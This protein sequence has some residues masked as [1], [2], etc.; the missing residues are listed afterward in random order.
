MSVSATSSPSRVRELLARF[1]PIWSDLLDRALYVAVRLTS[2]AMHA[3]PINTN[4]QTAKLLGSAMYRLDRKHRQRAL[5]NLRNS[6]PELTDAQRE[7]LARKSMQQMAMLF[8]EVLFTTRLIRLDTWT[9]YVELENF[10]PVMEMLLRQERGLILLTGHYG[11]WEILGYVLAT[12]GFE[13]TSIA[14]PLDNPYVSRFLFDVREKTGQRIIAKKGA[15]PEVQATM[16]K[17]GAVGFIADQNA[18]SKGVFVDFFGRK[19]STYKSIGLVAME[20]DVPV[21]IGY[22]RRL[23][24]RFYF[25]VGAQDIIYPQDWKSQ[26]DPLRYITQR[27]TKAIEEIVRV[28]PGQY[29]W[30][31]RRW[32]TRPRGETAEKYD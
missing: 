30:V 31:H 28:D 19:A 21:V 27:Y 11:N 13:T 14:R 23:G 20:Y 17:K 2:T 29:W 3:F 16:N 18:G 32:K 4:L 7:R 24:D 10:K 5:A 22:A 12:L 1:Q 8:V 15:T 26:D 9:R 25:K 6:F